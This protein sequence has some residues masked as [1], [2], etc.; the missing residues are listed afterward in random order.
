VADPRQDQS[1][2]ALPTP[3]LKSVVESGQ[4]GKEAGR[5]PKSV[6]MR[7]VRQPQDILSEFS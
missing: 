6:D 2:D 3:L 1:F 4:L 7:T 5:N